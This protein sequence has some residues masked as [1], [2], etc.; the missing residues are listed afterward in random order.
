M[1]EY[2]E[3]AY[4][5]T[6]DHCK[7]EDRFQKKR[8]FFN[9]IY[10]NLQMKRPQITRAACTVKPM[11]RPLSGSVVDFVHRSFCYE[12]SILDSSK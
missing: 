7:L 9:H 12:R 6:S 1:L 2:N 4:K 5:K 8:P 3:F 11:Y 10:A